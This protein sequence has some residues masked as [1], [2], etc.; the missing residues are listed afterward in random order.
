MADDLDG[1]VPEMAIEP[2]LELLSIEDAR[3]IARA[4]IDQQVGLMV[5]VIA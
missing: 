3:V 4:T 2:S 5:D 1:I